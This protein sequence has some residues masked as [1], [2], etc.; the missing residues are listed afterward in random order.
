MQQDVLYFPTKEGWLG[1]WN[2]F[3]TAV[4]MME[5]RV[6]GMVKR[7]AVSEALFQSVKGATSGPTVRATRLH[8]FWEYVRRKFAGVEEI[9][10]LLD[11]DETRKDEEG[12]VVIE[13]MEGALGSMRGT[14][15]GLPVE[16]LPEGLKEG[17]VSVEDKDG[18]T[19]PKWGFF[20]LPENGNNFDTS[21]WPNIWLEG[22]F[23]SVHIQEKSHLVVSTVIPHQQTAAKA[24]RGFWVGRKLP[25][26]HYLASKHGRKS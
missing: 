2:D 19:S 4:M 21:S 25:F 23:E 10:I 3:V 6:S 12:E 8:E 14:S 24:E 1:S 13:R 16:G 17:L 15:V 7:L 26:W 20:Q 9:V 11:G 22:K 18:W 5:P